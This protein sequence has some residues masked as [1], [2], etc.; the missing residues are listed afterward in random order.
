MNII[1]EPISHGICRSVQGPS[2][3]ADS[4]VPGYQQQLAGGVDGG[5]Y[6]RAMC[7]A[8]NGE[9]TPAAAHQGPTSLSAVGGYNPTAFGGSRGHSTSATPG[10][11]ALA[12][13]TAHAAA[14]AASY[15]MPMGPYLLNAFSPIV[16]TQQ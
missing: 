1:L 7:A 14:A 11:A 6:P 5:Q 2:G 4:A 9:P 3:S 12:G 8:Y 15:C 10:H 13:P 16:T